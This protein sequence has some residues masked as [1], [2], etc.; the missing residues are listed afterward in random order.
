MGYGDYAPETQLGR[1]AAL[2]LLPAGLVIIGFGLSCVKH[3]L[4]ALKRRFVLF[5]PFFDHPQSARARSSN[6]PSFSSCVSLT[7]AC[8]C[9]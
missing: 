8:A 6:L 1:A 4:C 7:F 3:A 9:M 2:F 5:D